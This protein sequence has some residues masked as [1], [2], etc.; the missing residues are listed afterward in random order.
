VAIPPLE[1]QAIGHSHRSAPPPRDPGPPRARIGWILGL[2]LMSAVLVGALVAV[3]LGRQ[4]P[5]DLSAA[6][7]AGPMLGS[8]I[9][10]TADLTKL[11]AEFGHMPVVRT[12]FPGLPPANAWSSSGKAGANQSAVVVSFKALPADILSGADDAVLSHFFDT[13]PTNHPIYY[14]YYHEPEDNIAAA[15]FS[16]ADYKAAWAHVVALATAAHNPQ[17]HSTLILMAYDLD[18][19]SG[20]NWK[21]YL[22]AG[23]IISVLGWDA[24]PSGAVADRNP[25]LTPPASFMG[26]AVAASKSVGLPFGFAE[27]GVEGM[28][29]RPAW[30]DQVG[31]YI[32]DSGALFGTYFQ[33]AQLTDTPSI[34]AWHTQVVASV[35]NVPVAPPATPAPA[36]TTTPP[37]AAPSTPAPTAPAKPT[38]PAPTPTPS[39]TATVTPPPPPPAPPASDWISGLAVSPANLIA[40]GQNHVTITFN[41]AEPADVTVCILNAQGSVVRRIDRPSRQAQKITVSYYGYDGASHRVPDGRYTVLV[42]ASNSLGGSTAVSSL[43]VSGP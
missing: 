43:T 29:G 19:T 38:T 17:L 42:V 41:L 34:A 1:R 31:Q 18:K 7:P 33:A 15:Q 8:S 26:P 10:S 39:A 30:L 14:S 12:Y 16:L 23:N 13:A 11:T 37:S 32:M 5:T 9:A 22:P 36:P 28:S 4:S 40:S 35:T 25:Q 3:G 20:R 21:D 24:Y 27:F 2:A 6:N